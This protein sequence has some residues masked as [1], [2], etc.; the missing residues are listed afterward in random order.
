MSQRAIIQLLAFIGILVLLN[1]IFAMF[2]VHEHIDIMGSVVITI[3][4]SIGMMLLFSRR[5]PKH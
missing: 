4:L 2:G 1:F 3:V 5:S